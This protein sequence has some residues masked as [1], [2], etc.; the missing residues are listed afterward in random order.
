MDPRL[1]AT[2]F[3]LG[4]TGV[5]GDYSTRDVQDNHDEIKSISDAST[6]ILIDWMIKSLNLK[7]NT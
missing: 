4:G 6:D 3:G 2:N 5:I 1:G 7:I